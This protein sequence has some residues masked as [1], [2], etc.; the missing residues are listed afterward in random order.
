M[1]LVETYFCRIHADANTD[2][3]TTEFMWCSKESRYFP[4]LE[5]YDVRE[6]LENYD[7]YASTAVLEGF[8][9]PVFQDI[10]AAC[11][12]HCS[13]PFPADL[14]AIERDTCRVAFAHPD[15]RAQ[16]LL[17]QDKILQEDPRMS[18]HRLG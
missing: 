14:L 16:I 9:A 3:S 8:Y 7:S 6:K 10:L 11:M 2:L 15:Y 13:V 4:K 5:E 12:S 18:H 17:L 1:C